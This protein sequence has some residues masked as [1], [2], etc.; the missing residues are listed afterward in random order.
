[1]KKCKQNNASVLEVRGLNRIL[2]EQLK[3][4]KF[5]CS[6]E[7]CGEVHEYDKALSHLKIC[8]FRNSNCV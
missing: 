2:K 4:F 3:S 8:Q 1:M 7:N 5:K 6:Y